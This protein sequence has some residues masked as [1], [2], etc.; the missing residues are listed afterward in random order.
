MRKIKNVI[1][2]GILSICMVV[3][4]LPVELLAQETE[5]MLDETDQDNVDKEQNNEAGNKQVEVKEFCICN[6]HCSTDSVNEDCTV[7]TANY[8]RCECA[9]DVAG[10]IT[11]EET[12]NPDA[13]EDVNIDADTNTAPDT[14]SDMETNTEL[15]MDA[16]DESELLPPQSDE[17]ESIIEEEVVES[18][19]E[20]AISPA[21]VGDTFTADML[22]YR[23]INDDVDNLQVEVVGNVDGTSASGDIV[24]PSTVSDGNDKYIVVRI[25]DSAFSE[26]SS[27]TSITI[28]DSVTSIGGSAFY[29]CSSLTNVTIPDGVTRIENY[30]FSYCR[31][32]TNITIPSSVI[33]IG[34]EAFGVCE[35]LESITIPDGVTSIGDVAFQYCL[36]LT[37]ITIPRSVTSIGEGAFVWCGDLTNVTILNDNIS[38]SMLAF[39]FCSRLKSFEIAVNENITSTPTIGKICFEDY[40]T[41]KR[42]LT[43]LTQ[44]GTTQLSNKTTPTLAEAVEAYNAVDDGNINDGYWYYWKLPEVPPVTG[45][46]VT[47]NVNIDDSEWKDCPKEFALSSDHRSTFITDLDDVPNGTYTIYDITEA[48]DSTGY[49]STDIT[50]EVNDTDA[51]AE[52]NYYTV[53]FY[54]DDTVFAE[55]IVLDNAKVS[56]PST[57]PTKGGYT[58]YR[59][60]ASDDGSTEFNFAE[61][62]ITARTDIY[63][64]WIKDEA[65]TINAWFYSGMENE[66]E[67]I[68][69]TLEE[70]EDSALIQTPKVKEMTDWTAL[71]WNTAEDEYSA[72]IQAETEIPIY[73]DTEYYGIYKKDIT[74]SYDINYTPDVVTDTPDSLTKTAYA[75]VHKTTSHN[76][77]EF[78]IA[79]EITRPGYT[80]GGW[81]TEAD[82]SGVSY[83][84]GSEVP[85]EEDTIL[86]AH[87]TR[88]GSQVY[89]VEH[90]CQNLNDNGYTRMDSDT[91]EIEGII[92][93][94]VTAQPKNYDG[95]TENREHS[96]RV[97]SGIIEKDAELTL[98]LYYDRN[99]YQVNFDLNYKYSG[100]GSVTTP[101]VQTLRYGQKLGSVT[102]PERK[103]WS[104][105]GWHKTNT[106]SDNS[107][108]NFDSAIEDNMDIS[109]LSSVTLYAGWADD[110]APVLNNA[111]YNT[112]YKDL[113]GWIIR[114]K[115]LIITVPVT[116]EGSGV[117]TAEYTLTSDNGNSVS[118]VTHIESAYVPRQVRHDESVQLYT[119]ENATENTT[120]SIQF[121]TENGQVSAVITVSEDYKGKIYLKCSD[122][123]GNNSGQ[124]NLTVENGGIIVEDN[125]P[126][127]S[128]LTGNVQNSKVS[129]KVT[130]SD[131]DDKGGK[132]YITGGIAEMTYQIDDGEPK[133]VTYKELENVKTPEGRSDNAPSN[134][135]D[136]ENNEDLENDIDFQSNIVTACDFKVEISGAGTH[137]LKVTAVDNAGNENSQSTKVSIS[138]G[139]VKKKTH[140]IKSGNTNVSANYDSKDTSSEFTYFV[141]TSKPPMTQ[142]R[143]PNTGDM[144][145]RVE[146]YATVA[147]IAGLLYIFL[148]FSTGNNGMTE[149]EKNE[150]V[151]RLAVWAKNGRKYRRFVAIVIIFG[152]LFYYHS[153][154]KRTS[155]EWKDIYEK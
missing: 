22:R 30:T 59:W 69:V 27:L 18:E 73:E 138:G 7:C 53:T 75:N 12:E 54:N 43:F 62:S 94:T 106:I 154:G 89:K 29:E 140:V 71:G 67:V 110:I 52:V 101:P 26:C 97:S 142:N 116:E 99:V 45:Y 143:E 147:M 37:S 76:Y 68:E 105:K 145:M 120:A 117:D 113:A 74:L 44:D 34:R 60:A 100:D 31:S 48:E 103:G 135:E 87:W 17:A 66:P 20:D 25:G 124:K 137:T 134:N 96:G 82:G 148:Y 51:E 90:Y 144:S 35:N 102:T 114:K 32:L 6:I 126:K 127:I 123:A 5:N 128:F 4:T 80:F 146:V 33:S 152:V 38:M 23:I 129:V 88:N 8:E 104:F 141:Q 24:I 64:S 46:S 83:E 28:P 111:S 55:Q 49:V 63:A 13:G 81:Y 112:G 85:F 109:E 2:A 125:A 1:L 130:V 47:I 93:E 92:G 118:G 86:Y 132:A 115:D 42:F 40:N 79:G 9:E 65:K 119:G 136:R 107:S 78:T 153:I 11:D 95:F 57:T 151:S 70:G 61:N 10:T 36:S 16:D 133:N 50:V 39:G 3:G 121:N 58:F 77:P 21:A 84:T 108:W 14:E 41:G 150:F 122:K 91:Q 155:V 19:A 139:K 149:Q 15:D 72:D 56:A 131:E 98:K